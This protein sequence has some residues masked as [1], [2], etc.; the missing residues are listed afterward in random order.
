[1][2]DAQSQSEENLA[3]LFLEQTPAC[4]WMVSA[5]GIFD[6]FFGDPTP[7]FG[8][9]AAD[10]TGR[11]PAAVLGKE[12]GVTWSG[13]FVRALKGETLLLN[14]RRGKNSWFVTV[15]P[16]RCEGEIRYAGAL[17]REITPWTHAE[18]ELRHTVLGALRA[19][20]FERTM[21][22][23]FLHD[24]VGQNLTALGLQLDLIRMDMES[25]SPET[26]AR[27]IEVQ[28]LL[29][30]MME[31]VREYSYE[32]NP[33]TVERAGLRAALDRLATRIRG[34]Y[35][36]ALRVNVDPFLKIDPSLARPMYQIGQ[37][38]VE[39]AVQHSSCSTIEIAV[40]STRTGTV[41]EVRDNGRGF[42]PADLIAGRR[43]LGLLS[44]EHYAAE[45]GLELSITSTR[46]FGTTVRAATPEAAER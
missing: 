11:L 24:S 30:E 2:P 1:M 45:A 6:R 14:E 40:K 43:G 23:K 16:V 7:L 38:A 35:P 32:L 37:E 25:I 20:E 17:A 19:Q 33:S 15:F 13:R 4:Q 27:A 36:G 10:L 31:S 18:Q 9:R 3:E 5:S 29:E 44:M 34:R 28:K 21:V 41:L 26:C 46:E 8:K 12:S 39:N 42:D 22:S